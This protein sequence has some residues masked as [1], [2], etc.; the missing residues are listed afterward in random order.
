MFF[1]ELAL[2]CLL[3]VGLLAGVTTRSL[4]ILSGRGLDKPG[5]QAFNLFAS[6]GTDIEGFDYRPQTPRRCDRLQTG[7]SSPENQ[8]PGRRNRSRGRHHHW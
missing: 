1:K 8:N 4:G 2:G 6:R 3:I 5:A 7:N